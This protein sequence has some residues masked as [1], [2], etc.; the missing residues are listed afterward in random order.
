MKIKVIKEVGYLVFGVVL[1][2]LTGALYALEEAG[3]DPKTG[4]C[5]T[6]VE[7]TMVTPVKGPDQAAVN[8]IAYTDFLAPTSSRAIRTLDKVMES[9]PDDI[10][11]V[12]KHY[13]SL[14]TEN[15]IL[16]HEAAMAAGGQ[17]KF[18][19]MYE[20]IL[21]NQKSTTQE[22]LLGYAKALKLDSK[23]F[24]SDI[25][26]HRFKNMILQQVREAKGL[27]VTDAPTFF[28][29]GRKLVGTRSAADFKRAIDIALGIVPASPEQGSPEEDAPVVEVNIQDAY[30]IGPEDAPVVIVEFSDFQCPFCGRVLP[31]LRDVLQ[32]YPKQVRWVFKHFPLDF[33]PDAPL[34]HTAALAAGEQGK[35]WEMHDLIFSNQAAMKRQHLVAYAKELKLDEE[36]FTK[37]LDGNKYEEK[38]NLDI[39]E[40]RRLGVSGTPTF[41]VN[42]RRLVG[43]K[44][45]EAFVRIIEAELQSAKAK[46]PAPRNGG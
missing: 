7:G 9:Y 6:V 46:T 30:A 4:F 17:G 33:H 34:A 45:I 44:P 5:G 26:T 20:K 31:T 23:K 40:G 3:C 43:A 21:A 18:W 42:G 35:F 25:K 22:T 12:F 19:E 38:I 1:L 27:G 13:P 15:A 32:R 37:A 16:A 36:E 2:M 28:I 10:Q 29:N 8:I 14:L 39:Q 41:F 11:V 24:S